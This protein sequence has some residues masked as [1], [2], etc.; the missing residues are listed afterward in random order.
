MGFESFST[1]HIHCTVFRVSHHNQ[2]GKSCQDM[3]IGISIMEAVEI[4]L[5]NRQGRKPELKL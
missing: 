4:Q 5:H 1:A 2:R 3:K